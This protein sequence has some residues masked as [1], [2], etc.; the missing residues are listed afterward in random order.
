MINVLRVDFNVLFRW[1]QPDSYIE[2]KQCE[3]L[4]S[5]EDLK[6][7]WP[8]V[9]TVLTKDQYGQLAHTPNLKVSIQSQR[10]C[11]SSKNIHFFTL[12]KCLY[13]YSLELLQVLTSYILFKNKKTNPVTHPGPMCSKLS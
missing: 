3:I 5:K 9:I 10:R 13:G 1:L 8:N 2:P 11:I 4:Y 6:C 12:L 7:S